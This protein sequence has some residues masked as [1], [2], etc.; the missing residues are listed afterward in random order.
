[1]ATISQLFVELK[2]ST[3]NFTK[4]IRAAQREAKEFE[5]TLKPMNKL[6][7]DFGKPLIAIGA[8]VAGAFVVMAKAAA[9][10]GDELSTAAERTGLTVQELARLK[11]AAEQ[12]QTSFDGVT[13]GLKFLSKALFA[14]GTGSKEQAILF[15][16]LGV[17]VKTSS[18]AIRPMGD[19]LADVS[20][21]FKT[22]PDGAEKSALAMKLF[23][24]A[25]SDL[26]PFL[27]TGK[28][29]LKDFGDE[30]QRMGLVM[31]D[32]DAKLGR[33]FNDS[34]KKVESALQGLS[35]SVS[36]ALL[37][38]FLSLANSAIAAIGWASD[39]AKQFPLVTKAAV[40]LAL[41]LGGAGGVL[42]AFTAIVSIAP[43]VYTALLLIQS[44]M[45][46]NLGAASILGAAR[47]LGELKIAAGLLVQAIGTALPMGVGAATASLGLFVTGG[48]VVA[49][50]AVGVL[51]GHLINLGIEFLGLQGKVDSTL[52]SM[53]EWIPVVGKMITG[54][55][56]LDLANKEASESTKRAA[57]ALA[58]RGVIVQQGTMTEFEYQTALGKAAQAMGKTMTAT[59]GATK[60]LSDQDKAL[61]DLLAGLTKGAEG[62]DKLAKSF[63]DELRPA[64]A[65]NVEL[66]KLSKA[67]AT[68]TQLVAVYADKIIQAVDVQK[69]HGVAV[70]GDTARLYEWA[71][72]VSAATKDAET[73]EKAILKLKAAFDRRVEPITIDPNLVPILEQLKNIPEIPLQKIGFEVK[74]PDFSGMDAGLQRVAEAELEARKEAAALSE[75]IRQMSA[76]G[77]TDAQI[78]ARLGT[79]IDKTGEDAKRFGIKLDGTTAALKRQSDAAVKAAQRAKDFQLAWATAMANLTT[80]IAEGLAEIIVDGG[81]FAEKMMSIAKDTAK[82]MLS[83]FLTGLISPLTDE[84]AKLGQKAAG[85]LSD[86]LLSKLPG[87]GST[88]AEGAANAGVS[89]A[90]SAAAGAASSAASGGASAASSVAGAASS[91]TP[92]AMISAG[93]SALGSIGT[94]LQ[95]KRL[96]GTMNA[97]EHNTRYLSIDFENTMNAILWPMFGFSNLLVDRAQEQIN[98][99]D[100]IYNVLAAQSPVSMPDL[101]AAQQAAPISQTISFTYGDITISAPASGSTTDWLDSLKKALQY[102]TDDIS[103][104]ILRMIQNQ[105]QGQ[106]ATG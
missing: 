99:L 88:A 57:E 97:V 16:A 102:N 45:N 48:L 59:K 13:T 8:A 17:E 32:A 84:F 74:I 47:N 58:K 73:A 26:I 71:V 75:T 62:G 30:A 42:L 101:R 9:N 50:A 70:S 82:G 2:L 63:A 86:K 69:R 90:T 68:D 78:T 96:E 7:E 79:Q 40:A 91:F 56:G 52:K 38:A 65:L 100:A 31:S 81:N 89:G 3:D 55:K 28:A 1:M 94:I 12:Q 93:I 80:R 104:A 10:Y 66:A 49:A 85:I 23:G 6:A 35:L 41:I 22:L 19:V 39:L 53:V 20:E 60:E 14:A 29:G 105:S 106:V 43:K 18:G 76:A 72:A 67:H 21:R 54:Q 4:P 37:P 64:D 95:L 11:F 103:S 46:F 98:Q 77:Y 15:K 44:A 36:S 87:L 92:M 51:V 34:I 25:G 83:A 24:K 5:K 61:R 33:E 27:N